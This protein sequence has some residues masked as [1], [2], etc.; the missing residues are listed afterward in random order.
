MTQIQYHILP[1]LTECLSG[2]ARLRAS[3]PIGPSG[4]QHPTKPV[5]QASRR[6]GGS[7]VTVGG[8]AF[9]LPTGWVLWVTGRWPPP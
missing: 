7:T 8:I 5:A 6:T 9:I 4:R 2:L 1:I 3:P